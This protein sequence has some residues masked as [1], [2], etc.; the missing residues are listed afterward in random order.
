MLADKLYALTSA[1]LS[2]IVKMLIHSYIGGDND[3][4]LSYVFPHV[5]K[6]PVNS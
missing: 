2:C 5:F 4:C 1:I 6:D 3:D